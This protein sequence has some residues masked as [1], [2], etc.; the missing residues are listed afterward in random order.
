MYVF[1]TTSPTKK[2]ARS[3][4][5]Q[6]LRHTHLVDICRPVSSPKLEHVRLLPREQLA[7]L[8]H[9]SLTG[10]HFGCQYRT[11]SL[12]LQF[13]FP[14]NLENT[15]S[16]TRTEIFFCTRMELGTIFPCRGLWV[17]LGRRH[18]AG[19]S[20]NVGFYFSTISSPSWATRVLDI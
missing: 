18:F 17:L 5:L 6:V 4:L 2:S 11:F 9:F 15:H 3:L 10:S 12:L 16:P 1:D 19:L 20:Q 14:V 8:D 13:A 7:K